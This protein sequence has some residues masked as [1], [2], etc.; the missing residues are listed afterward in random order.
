MVLVANLIFILIGLVVFLAFIAVVSG[1]SKEKTSDEL[2]ERM[3]DDEG[4]H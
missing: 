2:M 1:I 4:R 3:F